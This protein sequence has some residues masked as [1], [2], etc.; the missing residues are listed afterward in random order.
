MA[1]LRPLLAGTSLEEE[2]LRLAYNAEEQVRG[3]AGQKIRSRRLLHLSLHW[4]QLVRLTDH[5]PCRGGRQVRGGGGAERGCLG[6][7]GRVDHAATLQGQ[8]C[9]AC[10]G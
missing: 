10:R 1:Q 3:I 5:V 9:A 7:G 6:V 2:P 8:G 4:I